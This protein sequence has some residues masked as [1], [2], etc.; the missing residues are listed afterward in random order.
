M[1][2]VSGRRSVVRNGGYAFTDVGPAASVCRHDC[3]KSVQ[4][5]SHTIDG[6]EDYIF[7][8]RGAQ[9]SVMESPSN[10]T[11]IGIC[12]P[13]NL[14]PNAQ[15]KHRLALCERKRNGPRPLSWEL[16]GDVLP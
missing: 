6:E 2:G 4:R 13:A 3:A 12:I 7:D 10:D 8:L 11:A 15:G 5:A 1:V 9:R 16:E 14:E